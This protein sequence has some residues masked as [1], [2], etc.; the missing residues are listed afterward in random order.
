MNGEYRILWTCHLPTEP[1]ESGMQRLGSH[2]TTTPKKT[3]QR[4][5]HIA[6]GS[7]IQQRSPPHPT[8]N[9][10]FMSFSS[11]STHALHDTTELFAGTPHDDRRSTFTFRGKDGWMIVSNRRLSF[12]VPPA[13]QKAFY[14]HWTALVIGTERD[15]SYMTHGT[16]WQH[17]YKE[18]VSCLFRS[19][20]SIKLIPVALNTMIWHGVRIPR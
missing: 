8:L 10:D 1:S 15:P 7:H 18:R 16:R 6:V 2:C 3:A 20:Q 13:S 12:W 14:N 19:L 9:D 11:I 5:L 17:C 4:P